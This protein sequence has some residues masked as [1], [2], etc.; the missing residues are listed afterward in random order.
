MEELLKSLGLAP[1]LILGAV[2]ATATIKTTVAAIGKTLT[3]TK[4]AKAQRALEVTGVVTP[5]IF[6]MI[7]LTV[8]MMIN[9][10]NDPRIGVGV[11]AILILLLG[12][13]WFFTRYAKKHPDPTPRAPRTS[14]GRDPEKD[15]KLPRYLST[16]PNHPHAARSMRHAA[17]TSRPR[18]APRS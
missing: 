13:I 14:S 1:S 12:V 16:R 7:A 17:N 5:Y 2:L 3:I 10:G 18:R 6:S 8:F 4:S 11:L 15:Q 9:T